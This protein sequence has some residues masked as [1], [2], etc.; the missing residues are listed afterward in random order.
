VLISVV[1]VVGAQIMPTYLDGE[2]ARAQYRVKRQRGGRTRESVFSLSRSC[3]CAQLE[4]EWDL[5]RFRNDA[6]AGRHEKKLVF[7]VRRDV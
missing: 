2:Y 1:C 3:Q 6:S 7:R 4:R 5:N